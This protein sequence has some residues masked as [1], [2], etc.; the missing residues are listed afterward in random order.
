MYYSASSIKGCLLHC[1]IYDTTGSIQHHF[2]PLHPMV[3]YA[4]SLGAQECIHARL[5]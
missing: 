1:Q 3:Y 4:M 5:Y 2:M